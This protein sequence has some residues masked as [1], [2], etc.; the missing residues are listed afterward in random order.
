MNPAEILILSEKSKRELIDIILDLKQENQNLKEE[1]KALKGQ[2]E[3]KTI[4]TPSYP[5]R[6]L[7]KRWRKLGRP[8]GH[9]GTT[10]SKPVH[11]DNINH[12]KL[13]NCPDCGNSHIIPLPSETRVHIQE[14]IIPA[15]VVTTKFIRYAYWCPCCRKKI[16][17]PY[18]PQEIP[19]S[20]LGPNILIHAVL[21]KYLY[22][23]SYSKIAKIFR[24]LC[25]IKLTP[26]AL[27]QALQRISL[28][29]KVEKETL[30]EAIRGSPYLN[31]DE[32]GWRVA[33]SNHWLW[34]FVNERLAFYCIRRSRGRKVLKEILKDNYSGTIISDFLSAYNKVGKYRQK[35][36]VHLQR[37][38]ARCKELDT[39]LESQKAYKKLSRIIK[40]AYRLNVNRKEI[41]PLKLF[42]K[43]SSIEQRLF[44][45]ASSSFKSKHWSRLSQ[46]IL[47]YYQE[48]LTF[49]KKQGIPPHNN[50]AEQ[51]I[52]PNVIIRKISFQNMSSKGTFAHEVLM[53]LLQTL[54]NPLAKQNKIFIFF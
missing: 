27:A 30:L 3:K 46:R 53:S 12:Q 20:Y 14:D 39:S 32:T 24:N 42:Q 28:W 17:A 21:L 40:D 4:P 52:R 7:K 2:I 37:E 8:P 10:R 50:L 16:F 44:N 54:S 47:K 45:F 49:L 43:T 41:S 1:N 23:L 19:H 15:K 35:C 11:I 5:K 38:M 22:G 51:M 25:N 6:K 9:P 29:L 26:S 34:T 31:I 36:L 13:Y 18:A 48:L 33:G